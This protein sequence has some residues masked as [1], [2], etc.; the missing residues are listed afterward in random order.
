MKR[1]L[2]HVSKLKSFTNDETGELIEGGYISFC[3]FEST[4]DD[5]GIGLF[6]ETI[7]VGKE[8]ITKLTKQVTAD[9]F[10]CCVEVI[11]KQKTIK[12]KVKVVD[13][14]LLEN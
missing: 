1:R 12:G 3:E 10:P 13:V 5:D 9:I 4:S 7:W 14:E 11:T 8:I 2:L 6:T